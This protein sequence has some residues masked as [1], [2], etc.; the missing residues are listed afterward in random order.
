MVAHRINIFKNCEK[1]IEIEDDQFKSILD[2]E[3]VIEIIYNHY[4]V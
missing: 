2:Y 3:T 4:Y 1:I